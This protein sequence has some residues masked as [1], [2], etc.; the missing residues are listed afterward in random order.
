[1]AGSRASSGKEAPRGRSPEMHPPQVLAHLHPPRHCLLQAFHWSGGLE[2]QVLGAPGQKPCKVIA[3]CSH[4]V[5]AFV[6]NRIEARFI[7]PQTLL[8]TV[9]V[10]LLR[11]CSKRDLPPVV[12]IPG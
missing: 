1:M 4:L 12:E 7:K 5:A 9:L 11:C 2:T 3:P 8:L 6:R 10:R